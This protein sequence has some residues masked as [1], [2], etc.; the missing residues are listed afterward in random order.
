[1]ATVANSTATKS[2]APAPE[3]ASVGEQEQSSA[4][5]PVVEQVAMGGLVLQKTIYPDGECETTVLR[6]PAIAPELI[7]ATR[8][9]QR[10]RGR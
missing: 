4:E 8:A 5:A 3:Q 10:A 9:G 2:P 1:M 7:R 6:E